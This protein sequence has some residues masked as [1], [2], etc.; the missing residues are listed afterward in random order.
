MNAPGPGDEF[1]PWNP[2]IDSTL[3]SE[4]LALSTVFRPENVTTNLATLHELSAFSGIAP[5][6][7]A[8]FRPERLAVHELLIRVMADVYVA[9]GTKYEDL[10]TNF[11]GI[12]KTILSHYIIP[13]MEEVKRIHETLRLE[14]SNFI[15]GELLECFKEPGAAACP[16]PGKRSFFGSFGVKAKPRPAPAP[17]ETGEQRDL[18]IVAGWSEKAET[19]ATSLERNA[20]RALLSAA[21]A[22]RRKHGRLLGAPSMLSALAIP[23]AINEYGSELIGEHIEPYFHRAIA[24][25]G[26]NL[27]PPQTHPVIMN[28]K[29]ASASGKSTM[30]P[31][32]KQ[33][34]ARLG[35]RWNE[36][37]IISPDIW[38]K[39]LLDYASLGPARRYAGTLTGHEVAIVDKKLDRYMTGKGEKAQLPHLLIDRFRFDSF[40]ANQDAC[41][42]FLMRFG[43]R[44]YIFFMI[45]PP[46]ATVE[47]AWKRGEK[48]GRY[49]AVDDLLFHNVEAYTGMPRLFFAWSGE[50]AKHIHFEFLDNGVPEGCRP[51]TIAFGT[52]GEL[53]VLDIERILD[54]DRFKKINISA[55]RPAEVYATLSLAPEKNTDFLRKCARTIPVINFA[56]HRSGRIYAKVRDGEL[57]LAEEVPGDPGSKAGVAAVAAEF[58][59]HSLGGVEALGTLTPGQSPTI[60]AWGLIA[61]SID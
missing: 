22:I 60:G 6:D 53:N 59:R 26:Y 28:V 2:G 7:L 29:G 9:D 30:R 44:I 21:S 36:F 40:A 54:V 14:V 11:R 45:T 38:R 24:E 4:F 13:R 12:T 10:G 3:P 39:F 31:L 46:E 16:P 1:G 56:E 27:L 34:A 50:Q 37:A 49:K 41:S 17:L 52:N 43:Y 8:E 48:F 23:M 33:L 25:E 32:Q 47:R 20:Y 61:N 18:R 57:T 35:I 5:Q 51:R 42:R 55:R 15:G 58:F 19:A